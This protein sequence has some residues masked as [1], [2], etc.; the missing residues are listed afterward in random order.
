MH[1]PLFCLFP[2]FH[3]SPPPPPFVL[4]HFLRYRFPPPP[5]LSPPSLTLSFYLSLS[6]PLPLSFSKTF[7][8]AHPL[9]LFISSSPFL[10]PFLS[11]LPP[12]LTLLN[13]ISNSLNPSFMCLSSVSVYLSVCLSLSLSLSL[14]HTHTHTLS[15]SSF[16][17][18]S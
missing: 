12:P 6:F 4:H 14:S 13:T 16:L 15:L 10:S 9:P 2:S 5:P 3:L 7:T 18:I 17:S 8:G 11:F 1:I